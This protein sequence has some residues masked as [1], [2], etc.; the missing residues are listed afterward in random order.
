MCFVVKTKE[1]KKAMKTLKVD[2][3]P[4][5]YTKTVLQKKPGAHIKTRK[6][7]VIIPSIISLFCFCSCS[8][9]PPVPPLKV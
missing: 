6:P 5:R 7:S 9:V 3:P 1:K 4:L 2:V 8:F